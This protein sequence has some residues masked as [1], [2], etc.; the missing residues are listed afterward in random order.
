MTQE[1]FDNKVKAIA[2]SFGNQ[3]NIRYF[4]DPSSPLEGNCNSSTYTILHK[5]GVSEDILKGLDI[6]IQGQHWGW[7]QLKPWTKKEQQEAIEAQPNFDF[8]SKR[9]EILQNVLH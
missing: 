2:T 5:A 4:I 3:E 1:E 9:Y 6:K 8:E 7:G